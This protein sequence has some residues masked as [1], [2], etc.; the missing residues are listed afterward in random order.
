VLANSTPTYHP[1]PTRN[2]RQTRSNA[3]FL[4]SLI[5]TRPTVHLLDVVLSHSLQANG[6]P[7]VSESGSMTLTRPTA[8]SS[9]SQMEIALLRLTVLFSGT[10]M[11]ANCVASRCKPSSEVRLRT[12][13]QLYVYLNMLSL[14]SSSDFASPRD[15]DVWFSDFSVGITEYL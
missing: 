15:Q 10:V 7:S 13:L 12:S 9:C 1:S 11:L 8:N 5:A 3:M 14:G 2:S 4:P 6:Q